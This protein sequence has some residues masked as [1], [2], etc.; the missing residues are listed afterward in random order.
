MKQLL[1]IFKTVEKSEFRVDKALLSDREKIMFKQSNGLI[2]V[3]WTLLSRK[4]GLRGGMLTLNTVIQTQM[5]LNTQ[6]AQIRHLSP[7]TPKSPTNSFW[8][9]VNWSC[10]RSIKN[11][12]NA[13][14]I[15]SVVCN[16]FNATKRS[17]C[18][19]MWQW[20]KHGCTTFPRSQIGCQLSGQ[21]QVKTV[22]SDQ[23]CKHQ[24]AM[25]WLPY[26]GMHKVSCSL[27]TFRKEEPSITNI[28]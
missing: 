26:F 12:N 25:F 22:Q 11:N 24:Q 18:I 15:Q 17:F 13:S 10:S 4:Q 8:P 28:I 7:K 21:Q 1:H 3:I 2:S 5:M 16:C 19:N 9:I 6:L 27:I 23:R 20:L 14:T